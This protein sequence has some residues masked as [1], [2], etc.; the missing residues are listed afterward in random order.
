MKCMAIGY[1][2]ITP[3][4]DLMSFYRSF[5][6]I[7][8]TA[9]ISHALNAEGLAKATFGDSFKDSLFLAAMAE[10]RYKRIDIHVRDYTNILE[11][12]VGRSPRALILTARP[13][14][15]YVATDL[16]GAIEQYQALVVDL[17]HGHG[18]TRDN[19]KFA[20]VNALGAD[21]LQRAVRLLPEAG[22]VAVISE[23]FMVYLNRSEKLTF[24]NNVRRILDERGGVLITSD[25]MVGTRSL[26]K[27]NPLGLLARMVN[28]DMSDV[29]F[30]D[31]DEASGFFEGAGFSARA[32]FEPVE[33]KSITTLHLENDPNSQIAMKLPVWVL[34]SRTNA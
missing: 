30:R 34:A 25:V 26:N 28:R 2:G 16:P 32:F 3:T 31:D 8:F 4:A 15:T 18:L 20:A 27:P 7:P 11:V 14:I 5:S 9:E 19:I 22:P 10:A 29:G 12:A 17:A 1:A 33:V 21:E 24:L 23:G 13:Q 6:D